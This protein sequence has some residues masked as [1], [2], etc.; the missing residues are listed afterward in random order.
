M[1]GIV[2]YLGDKQ[3]QPILIE[4]LKRLEYRGYDSA[5]IAI[6][7]GGELHL[8]RSAGRISDLEKLLEDETMTPI[9]LE[10]REP[11][12]EATF[13]VTVIGV[14]ELSA[15]TG[16]GLITSQE[17]LEKGLNVELPAPT[18]FVC[19]AKG[20]DPA[21]AVRTTGTRAGRARVARARN[22]VVSTPGASR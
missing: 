14:L 20:A 2:A 9:R 8:V 12:S 19:L 4:G 1:C 11:N 21:S 16:Y 15:I 6:F 22:S 10:V 5:G 18:Y 3:A 13:D 7:D 17:T